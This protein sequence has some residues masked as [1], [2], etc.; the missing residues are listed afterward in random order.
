[1]VPYKLPAV[2]K[3]NPAYVFQAPS[4]ESK[5]CSRASLKSI[6]ERE[7][8]SERELPVTG[9][10]PQAAVAA[11]TSSPAKV[12]VSR[13]RREAYHIAMASASIVTFLGETRPSSS[14]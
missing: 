9:S 14:G 13:T 7:L 11:T 8:A 6:E 12:V 2:S 5:L 1:M 4:V 3:T 10:P